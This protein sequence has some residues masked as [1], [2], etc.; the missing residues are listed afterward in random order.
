[1]Y[2]DAYHAQHADKHLDWKPINRVSNKPKAIQRLLVRSDGSGDLK[3]RSRCRVPRPDPA[4]K[5]YGHRLR[6]E[7]TR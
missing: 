3:G 5:S 4:T 1:M 2:E 6:L 7:M